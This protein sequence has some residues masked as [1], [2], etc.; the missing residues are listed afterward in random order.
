MP[1]P[2]EIL[3]K[4]HYRARFA[5]GDRD[6]SAA[7]SFRSQ[8]FGITTPDLDRF[9]DSCHHILIED[10][11]C[12]ML[13]GYFRVLHLADGACVP[14][15]Y[16]AQFYDL[17][18]LEQYSGP[19]A[20]MGRFCIHPNVNSPDILRLSWGALTCIV[21]DIGIQMLFG[22]TS[23]AGTQADRY[24][25]AFAVLRHRHLAPNLWLPQVGSPK[26]FKF[27]LLSQYKPDLK[28][29]MLQMPPL[30]RSYL[31]MGGWVSDHAVVDAELNTMHVLTGLE[32]A[33]IPDSR[34][35]L[36]RAVAG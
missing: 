29:A 36:L 11:R 12:D 33:T 35:R 23:F 21:D 31:A 24:L 22:C 1:H 6:L 20:E 4:G 26:V 3:S 8:C 25:D 18:G 14:Q 5:Q 13:V 27:D 34:K 15:S 28:R 30:L 7:Q 10:I 2:T 17:S 9:D 32:V 19:M 16:S